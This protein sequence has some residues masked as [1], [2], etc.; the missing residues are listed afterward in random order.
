M[1]C[2][3]IHNMRVN[4]VENLGDKSYLVSIVSNKNDYPG[5]FIIGSMFYDYV[6]YYMSLR[7]PDNF[8]DKFFIH[9]YKEKCT[10]QNIGIHWIGQV[11]YN[12]AL[13]LNLE[14]PK[15]YTGDCFR[16]SSATLI[17]ESCGGNQMLRQAGRWRSDLIAQGYIE[18]SLRNRQLIY[19]GVV[20]QATK[21]QAIQSKIKILSDKI[22]LAAE[23][24]LRR[25]L[26]CFHKNM[27]T[28][29]ENILITFLKHTK[30]PLIKG[31]KTILKTF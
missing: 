23:N 16:R 7:P 2:D 3:E 26:K 24:I 17:A 8:S 12:I 10:R 11:P 31:F 29:L 9:C 28:F 5:Q 15:G 4:N 13:Y 18:N 19:E 25:F 30:C 6:E 27:K 14:N 21:K 22:T 1:R 20:H